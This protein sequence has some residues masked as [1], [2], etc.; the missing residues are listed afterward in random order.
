MPY[1]DDPRINRRQPMT[2]DPNH[3]GWIVGGILA[4]AVICGLFFTFGSKTDRTDTA[5]TAPTTTGSATSD[6]SKPPTTPAVPAKPGAV[7][8]TAPR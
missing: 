8:L 4:F 5:A 2:N 7:P 6:I 3:T 1:Q